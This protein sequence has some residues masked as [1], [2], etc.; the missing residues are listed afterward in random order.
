[1]LAIVAVCLTIIALQQINFFPS[2]YSGLP[3]SLQNNNMGYGL[4]PINPDG[5]INVKFNPSTTGN[6]NIEP[7]TTIA[8]YLAEPIEVKLKN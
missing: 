2:T 5:S 4:V 7:C 1:M 3:K 8:L 6:F